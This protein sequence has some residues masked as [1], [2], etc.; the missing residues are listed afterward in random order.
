MRK[1]LLTVFATIITALA[2]TGCRS[3][4]KP[5]DPLEQLYGTWKIVKVEVMGFGAEIEKEGVELSVTFDKDGTWSALEG[6]DRI[7]GGTFKIQ[8]SNVTCYY[9]GNKIAEFTV[10]SITKDECVVR[11]FDSESNV[12]VL[13]TGARQ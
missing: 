13:L 10:V 11:I 3:S 9:E 4:D 6:T 7:D 2:L 12:L 5:D 1:V 8:D